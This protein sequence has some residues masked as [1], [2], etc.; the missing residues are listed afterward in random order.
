MFGL[1]PLKKALDQNRTD[2]LILTMDMLCQLSYKGNTPKPSVFGDTTA[3]LHILVKIRKI[4]ILVK[5]KT[6]SI[7]FFLGKPHSKRRYSARMVE[8]VDTLVSGT[9][10][11]SGM[12][13]RVFFR[14]KPP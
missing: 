12:E 1:L 9:S 4:H 11:F 2:D 14:A 6:P 8:L 5:G 3:N 10:A 13:V 7:D